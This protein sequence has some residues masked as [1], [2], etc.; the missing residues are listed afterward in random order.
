[1]TNSLARPTR[2][3]FLAALALG[4]AALAPTGAAADSAPRGADDCFTAQ[5]GKRKTS[6]GV[7]QWTVR[8]HAEWCVAERDGRRTIVS[9]ERRTIVRTGTNWRLISRSGSITGKQTRHATAESRFHFRLRY[10][11]LEQNCYP[12]VA[13]ELWASGAFERS[14]ETGCG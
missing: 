10:P 12:R 5:A 13:I 9:A 3:T 11:Y 4:L 14:V 1:M 2:F 7:H 6:L 8:L